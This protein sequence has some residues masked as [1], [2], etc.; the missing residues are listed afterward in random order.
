[1][2]LVPELL[3]KVMAPEAFII[4]LPFIIT[5]PPSN[6]MSPFNTTSL[7]TVNVLLDSISK[8]LLL[9]TI[10]SEIVEFVF[11]STLCAII[12]VLALVG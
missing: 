3:G 6:S 5:E 1:M 12:T 10:N 8:V 9:F 2:P 4:K 11:K 7:F